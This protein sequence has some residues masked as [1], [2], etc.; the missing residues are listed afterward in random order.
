MAGNGTTASDC[1]AFLQSLDVPRQWRGVDP[2]VLRTLTEEVVLTALEQMHATS[3]PGLDGVSAAVYPRMPSAFV[4][5]ML[6]M[7]QTMWSPGVVPESWSLAIEAVPR[8]P[9]LG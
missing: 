7:V 2:K 4:P 5:Q 1:Q 6:H 3:S 8:T 9:W